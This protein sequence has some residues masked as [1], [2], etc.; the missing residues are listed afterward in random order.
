MRRSDRVA[1]LKEA[2][3]QF[4]KSWDAWKGVGE[5]RLEQPGAVGFPVVVLIA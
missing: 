1:A 3:A 5:T 4:H 2:K